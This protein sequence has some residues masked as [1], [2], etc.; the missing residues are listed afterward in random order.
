MQ[1]PAQLY[2][3]P[4]FLFGLILLLHIGSWILLKPIW[5]NGPSDD[6]FQYA[7]NANQLIHHT[8]HLNYDPYPNRF[9]VF[10]P[11]SF[12][13]YLFG[14]SPYTTSLWPLIASLLTLCVV[15]VLLKKV[16]NST[17]ALFAAF[18][19]ATNLQQLAYS[20]ELY[21][22]LIV[23]FYALAAVV[24]L[25]YGR[26]KSDKKIL[27]ATLFQLILLAGFMTKETML[28]LG[29]FILLTLITDLF[30]KNHLLFW[31]WTIG[32]SALSIL[33]FFGFYYLMTGD[34]LFRIRSLTDLVQ[35]R[36][37]D[38][39]MSKSIT[40][41]NSANLFI[42][43]NHNLA[44]IFLLV[45]SIPLFLSSIKGKWNQLNVYISVYALLMLA[46]LIIIFH[47]PK[48]GIIYMQ[49]RHWMFLLAPLSILAAYFFSNPDKKHLRIVL[50][51]LAGLS[52]CN[53]I[54]WG[55]FRGLLFSLFLV[56]GLVEYYWK[57]TRSIVWT[58]PFFILLVYFISA[59]TNYRE[60]N[61]NRSVK[62]QNQK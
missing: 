25:Y 45:F 46:Q 12:I 49:D 18:L 28:L 11:T 5:P 2:K 48:M 40:D 62:I 1:E 23:S 13:F 30:Q 4:Y 54:E 17:V 34:P 15:F 20:L 33:L 10:V 31:K 6:P 43:L 58:I 52:I 41:V 24:V 37:L 14:E 7:W 9:G 36:I 38:E 61:A 8:F 21:P 56:A 42:W 50:F 39:A 32:L 22:D 60:V 29:P 53:Y 3:K 27:F 59:N 51:L 44:Y 57:Q 55:L 26:E 35:Y 16:A 19:L 47:T